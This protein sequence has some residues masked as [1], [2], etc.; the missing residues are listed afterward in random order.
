M[1]MNLVDS[2]PGQTTAKVDTSGFYKVPAPVIN[3]THI[4]SVID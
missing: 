4:V 3:L 1:L 2:T